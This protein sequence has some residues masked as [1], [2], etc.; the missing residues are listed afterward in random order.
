MRHFPLRIALT[1]WFIVASQQIG[2]ASV[3]FDTAA[4]PPPNPPG[5]TVGDFNWPFHR[6]QITSPTKLETVGGFF[7][8]FTGVTQHVFGAVIRL[9]GP[10]DFP[11][12]SDLTTPDVLGTTLISVGTALSAYDGA[13]SLTLSPGWYALELGTGRFGASS[14]LLFDLNLS[15]HTVDLDPTQSTIV[16]IQTGHPSIG[17][18]F[19]PQP[20]AFRFFGT[21]VA[22]PEPAT[23]LLLGAGLAGL[24]GVTWRRHRRT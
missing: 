6:F 8:N 22:V 15:Q 16:A 17:P 4:N 11:D 5:V 3:I 10:A 1:I 20:G 9:S 21:G 12:S 2:H 13:L 23:L 14:G 19:Y 18:G 7:R 24:A